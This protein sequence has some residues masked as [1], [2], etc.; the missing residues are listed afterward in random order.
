MA[1]KTATRGGD[2]EATAPA[3]RRKREA[4]SRDDEEAPAG[5]R[6]RKREAAPSYLDALADSAP[7]EMIQA[8]LEAM[9]ERNGDAQVY[10]AEEAK[11]GIIGLPLRHLC[12]R[13][14]FAQTVLP[15]GRIFHI[16][17][18]KGSNKSSL[19]SEFFRWHI[20]YGGGGELTEVE[21]K[22]SPD[23]RRSILRTERA[24][25][26]V[27]VGEAKKLEDWQRQ[28]SWGVEDMVD[29][30]ERTFGGLCLP[31]CFGVDAI[32]SAITESESKKMDEDGAAGRG[33]YGASAGIISNFL[34]ATP[35]MLRNTPF[36]LVLV[37]HEKEG[38]DARNSRIK[39]YRQPGGQAPGFHAT[40]EL[41]MSRGPIKETARSKSKM[42]TMRLKKNSLGDPDR[43]LAVNFIW[44][45]TKD[46][47]DQPLQQAYFDWFGAST[48]LLRY[49]YTA[50]KT[51]FKRVQDL[52]DVS[53]HDGPRASS[54]KLGIKKP[55]S[56]SEFGMIL[57]QHGELMNQLHYVLK[58]CNRHSFIP[59]S[60]MLSQI[61]HNRTNRV[62]APPWRPYVD[63]MPGDAMELS[64]D[65][66]RAADDAGFEGFGEESYSD[67]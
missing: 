9:R 50:N 65:L 24:A 57:E 4:A 17:G 62:D 25:R 40:F 16:F 34:K 49:L 18:A 35:G 22:D 61:E 19:L 26:R 29:W 8:S 53:F 41:Q 46:A 58:I 21:A 51:Q 20:D 5:S 33:S 64:L 52:F 13:Y 39:V 11:Y 63:R 30:Q 15:L 7:D 47:N 60:D 23:L 55:V 28:V 43:Q 44:M 6:R 36:S 10:T 32:M 27:G 38:T 42:L 67:E 31:V 3:R 37:N 54:K 14:L 56:Y 1:K 48:G 66:Q 2:E 59:G 12:L 45:W